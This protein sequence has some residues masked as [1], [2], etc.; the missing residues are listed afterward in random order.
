MTAAAGVLQADVLVAVGED[1]S[2][3]YLK[4]LQFRTLKDPLELVPFG[5]MLPHGTRCFIR[6]AEVADHDSDG[7]TRVRICIEMLKPLPAP[8]LVKPPR[9]RMNALHK[10]KT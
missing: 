9:V 7:W 2:W 8:I 4:S 3:S 10:E 5:I 6:D 1:F